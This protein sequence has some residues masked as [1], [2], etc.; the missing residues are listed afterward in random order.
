M[1]EE[2]YALINTQAKTNREFPMRFGLLG[3]KREYVAL[4]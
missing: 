3:R 4:I 2:R 1:H